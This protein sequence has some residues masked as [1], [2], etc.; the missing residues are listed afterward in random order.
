VPRARTVRSAQGVATGPPEGVVTGAPRRWLLLEGLVLL[1]GALIAFAALGQPWW[2]V[3]AAILA[4]DIAM[5]GYAAGTRPGAHLYNLT[6]A[7]PLP[8]IMLGAGYWQDN[9]LVMAL[10]LIWLA[11]IGLDRLLSTGLK[12]NDRFTHTHL[13]DRPDARSQAA[14]ARGLPPDRSG[15]RSGST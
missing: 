11:H 12:Y 1:A 14:T 13:G 7:T 2:L 15:S 6:H 9:R 4:P 8:A 5:T 10:A 3:P